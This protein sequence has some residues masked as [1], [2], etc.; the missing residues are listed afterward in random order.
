M[1]KSHISGFS[2]TKKTKIRGDELSKILLKTVYNTELFIKT[3]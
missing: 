3:Y 1:K 2:V